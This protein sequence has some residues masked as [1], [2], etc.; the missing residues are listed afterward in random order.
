MFLFIA[1]KPDFDKINNNDGYNKNLLSEI[2]IDFYTII[3][4]EVE[5]LTDKTEKI[6]VPLIVLKFQA[7][8]EYELFVRLIVGNE[9]TKYPATEAKPTDKKIAKVPNKFLSLK[10]TVSHQL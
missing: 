4:N 2:L 6:T 7:A 1:L 5:K 10:A 3:E 8:L 9:D